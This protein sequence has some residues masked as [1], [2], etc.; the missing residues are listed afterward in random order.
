MED[1]KEYIERTIDE[2]MRRAGFTQQTPQKETKEPTTISGTITF[3]GKGT[4]AKAKQNQQETDTWQEMEENNNSI[5][6]EEELPF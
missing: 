1:L 4:L 6:D 2:A 5:Y 3:L